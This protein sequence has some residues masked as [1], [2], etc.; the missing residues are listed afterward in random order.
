[1][2][3]AWFAGAREAGEPEPDAMAVATAT[4]DGV[5]SVRLVLM[6]GFDWRGLVF[7]TNGRSRKAEEM[8]ANPLA[9]AVFRWD[10]VERQIRFSGPVSLVDEAE[11]DAYFASRA[12][13]SQLGAW[14]SDQSTV[15]ESR[16]VLERRLAAVVLRYS[17]IP[18]PRPP[19]WGGYRLAPR[20][21]EFWQEGVDRL[22]DRFRYT[23]EAGGGW[24]I[25]RLSP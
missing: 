19:W 20:Q 24:R 11:S 15:I 3:A 4:P 23:A 22:H 2:F 21:V 8:A 14:A 18:V 12:R 10:R 7:F 5:P 13:G 16:S 17:G 25:E 1:L 9:A 6:R